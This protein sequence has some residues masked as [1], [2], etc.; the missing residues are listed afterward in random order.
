M[1]RRNPVCRYLIGYMNHMREEHEEF[2]N[3]VRRIARARWPAADR[4]GAAIID[5]RERD[6]VFETEECIH[7]IEAVTSRKLEKAPDDIRKLTSLAT[8]FQRTT[9]TKA[10]RCWFVTRDE[11][12]PDQRRA[13]PRPRSAAAP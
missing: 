4:G 11:P 12:T 13:Y 8:K 1:S 3:E 7:L 5:G 9:S 10:V 2:E 6:G